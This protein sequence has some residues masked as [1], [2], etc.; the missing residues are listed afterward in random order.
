MLLSILTGEICEQV[1][2]SIEL[3]HQGQVSKYDAYIVYKSML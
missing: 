2:A 1:Q 3:L